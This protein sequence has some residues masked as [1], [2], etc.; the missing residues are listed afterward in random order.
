MSRHGMF[1]LITLTGVVLA[2]TTTLVAQ[3]QRTP[4]PRSDNPPVMVLGKTVPPNEPRVPGQVLPGGRDPGGV[5]T[6]PPPRQMGQINPQRDT[7]G[8]GGRGPVV[9]GRFPSWPI[10][11]GG[12][13]P[14]VGGG[15]PPWPTGPGGRGP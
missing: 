2:A 12:R 1:G 15:L 7:T 14:V 3:Q 6:V 13:G 9:G 10:G 4:Q 8:P 11:P 5:I